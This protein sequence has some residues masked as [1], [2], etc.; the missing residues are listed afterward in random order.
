MMNARFENES[1]VP[2]ETLR[3]P[4]LI[5]TSHFVT[6]KPRVK[7]LVRAPVLNQRPRGLEKGQ[8]V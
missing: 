2:R 4:P 5:P 1:R 3:N 7:S 6:V 8:E